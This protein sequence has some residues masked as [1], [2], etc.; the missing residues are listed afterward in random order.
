MTV[1]IKPDLVVKKLLLEAWTDPARESR[2][3]LLTRPIT[4]LAGFWS[5]LSEKLTA[6]QARWTATCIH[7][8]R[9]SSSS[10]TPSITSWQNQ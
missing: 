9:N 4:L 6:C 5:S 3:K 8:S 1:P 2:E 10:L 7:F